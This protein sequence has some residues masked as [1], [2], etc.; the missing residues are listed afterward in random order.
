MSP[1][2]G[3]RY[4]LNKD[5]YKA[6][7]TLGYALGNFTHIAND[8]LQLVETPPKAVQYVHLDDVL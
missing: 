8:E 3:G 2:F 4:R 5:D 6:W 7:T 1:S